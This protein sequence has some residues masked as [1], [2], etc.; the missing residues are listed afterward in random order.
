MSSVVL[1]AQLWRCHPHWSSAVTV[2]QR[3]EMRRG[4]W[5]SVVKHLR[6]ACCFS[7]M[8]CVTT[9]DGPTVRLVRLMDECRCSCWLKIRKWSDVG[10]QSVKW[11][12]D[13]GQNHKFETGEGCEAVKRWH[14]N[15]KGSFGV[16]RHGWLSVCHVWCVD[17]SLGRLLRHRM[18]VRNG[19]EIHHK[20]KRT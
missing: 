1:K 16:I 20:D 15:Q 4:S 10:A 5:A 14:A 7:S 8:P 13:S 6:L 19:Q 11:K 12:T 18:R 9:C 2:C 3:W 17:R